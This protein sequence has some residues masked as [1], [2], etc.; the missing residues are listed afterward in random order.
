M[1]FE[2]PEAKRNMLNSF[3]TQKAQKKYTKNT[4][5]I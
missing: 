3:S 4:K 5:I 2:D 1:L